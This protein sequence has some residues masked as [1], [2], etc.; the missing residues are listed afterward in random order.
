MPTF[1]SLANDLGGLALVALLLGLV[2]L[3]PPDTSLD[4]VEA[5]D[6][7]RACVPRSYP[8]LVTGDSE[9]PGIDI[10]ILRVVAEHLGVNLLLD[11]NDAMGRDFNPRNWAINRG[12]CQI[13]AGGVVD[14]TLTRSF[15]DIGPAYAETGW[16]IVAPE[17]LGDAG[18]LT[19]G[20]LTLVSGLDRIGL[21]S[22]LRREDVTIRVVRSAESL[23]EGVA[24][25]EFDAGITEALLAGAIAAENDWWVAYLP[26]ELARHNLVFGLWK[27]DLTLKRK[28]VEAF[29]KIE[30]DGTLAAILERYGAAPMARDGMIPTL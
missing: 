17:P 13:L 5:N 11:P 8:P 27:G 10:E 7:I 29:R 6:A 2:T 16:A 19:V 18:G 3:L 4:E 28:V 12:K 1:R 20:V 26:E 24:S 25:G 21:S 14:S 23:A 22:Y 30:S 9:R 15:L